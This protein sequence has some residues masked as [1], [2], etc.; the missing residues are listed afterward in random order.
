MAIKSI[1][2]VAT[3]QSGDAR[4]LSFATRLARDFCAAVRVVAADLDAAEGLI[5]M[6]LA[7]GAPYTPQIAEA[8]GEARAAAAAELRLRCAKAC[9]DD[10]VPFGDANAAPGVSVHEPPPSIP[11]SLPHAVGLTDLVLIGQD[12]VDNIGR[13]QGVEAEILLD[14]RTPLFVG[15][16]APERPISTVAVAWD[17]SLEAGRAVRAALPFLQRAGRIVAL[18]SPTGLDPL[19]DVSFEALNA[20]L[21]L[22]GLAG[23]E[24]RL[25]G[26]GPVAAALCEAA[27]EDGAS[28]LVAGAYG[29]SRLRE[30]LFGGVT[31]ALLADARGPSLLLAH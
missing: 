21:A 9:L 19:G 22:H 24:R 25:L 6:G 31:R 8:V 10:D 15:R 1:V 17:G 20:Y 18:Q 16:S 7:M 5:E 13:Q 27:A 11:V 23:A 2:A 29:A 30:M 28:M 3:G 12:F 26:K 4:M 14:L